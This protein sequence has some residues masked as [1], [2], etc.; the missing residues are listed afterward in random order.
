MFGT[1]LEKL[2]AG[3]LCSMTLAGL[4]GCGAQSKP[5]PDKPAPPGAITVGPQTQRSYRDQHAG[6]QAFAH[7]GTAANEYAYN[8]LRFF[9][10]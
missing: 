5:L 9:W 3:V 6:G 8:A 7:D 4:P 1:A 10:N 2:I